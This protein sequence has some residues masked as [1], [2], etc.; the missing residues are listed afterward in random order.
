MLFLAC[1]LSILAISQAVFPCGYITPDTCRDN[2]LVSEKVSSNLCF[3]SGQTCCINDPDY[4]ETTTETPTSTPSPEPPQPTCGVRNLM[5]RILSAQIS[6]SCMWPWSVS[7]RGRTLPGSTLSWENS[8]PICQGALI[9]EKYVL[10]T[11]TCAI[12][13][14]VGKTGGVA[15]N[16]MVIP[17]EQ[18]TDKLDIFGTSIRERFHT[19]KSVTFNPG[20]I[21]QTIDEVEKNDY[22]TGVWADNNLAILE[23]DTPVEISEC[24][25]P[26]CLP[27][28]NNANNDWFDKQCQIA[29]WGQSESEVTG[30]SVS[31]RH[32]NVTLYNR[33]ICSII[34]PT[35][36][37]P[38]GT[39]CGQVSQ[40]NGI[41]LGDNGGM[42]MC[43]NEAGGVW[44]LYGLISIPTFIQT[45]NPANNTPLIFADTSSVN[46]RDWIAEVTTQ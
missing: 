1:S 15:D 14:T 10:T 35:E 43:K 42:V 24:R 40:E 4:V 28:A 17:G 16:T 6:E 9:G 7:I 37:Q 25:S 18:V 20:F 30:L 21:R 44:E 29:A 5:S 38:A 22:A 19:V 46:V 26:I 2:C 12:L 31:L 33:R 3:T 34:N 32:T 11:A 36:P 27:D 39:S 41:C 8:N 13:T 23:L 45:C